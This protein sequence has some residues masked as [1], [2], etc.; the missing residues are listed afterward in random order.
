SLVRVAARSVAVSVPAEVIAATEV[1]TAEVAAV[2]VVVPGRGT[3]TD[4]RI[5]QPD[6]GEAAQ[7]LLCLLAAVGAGHDLKHVAH[8]HA[9]L[10]ALA[11]RGTEVFVKC[12]A[13]IVAH[14]LR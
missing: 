9:L 13:G 8:R 4:R 10:G 7:D 3:V 6:D 5:G 2:S 11:A 12:H 14:L 1:V